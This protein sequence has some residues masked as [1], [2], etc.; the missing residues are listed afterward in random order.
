MRID[1]TKQLS[2]HELRSSV[3]KFVTPLE[4]FFIID[5]TVAEVLHTL[6]A[7][8]NVSKSNYF[9]IIHDDRSLA[10]II[11]AP[12]L[13]YAH[14]QTRISEILEQEI[15]KIHEEEPLEK[16][17]QIL[18]D[19]QILI[20][21]VVDGENKLLGVLE[22]LPHSD[23]VIY[24]PK[25]FGYKEMKSDIFQFI[26]FSLEQKKLQ[27][28]WMG[29]RY[30]MPWLLCNLVGGLI[31][32]LIGEFFQ[33]TLKE[34]VV[35]ALFIPLVLTLSESISIQSMTLSLRFLHIRK[36]QWRQVAKRI[37]IE[38]K[39]S[40]LIAL[41]CSFFIALFY[42]LW[43]KNVMP[44]IAITSSL[45]MAMVVAATFGALFPIFLHQFKLDPKVAAGPVIL[46]LTDIVTV[47]IYLGLST[48]LLIN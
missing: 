33:I 11:T 47:A 24:S 13:L 10:G 9:Y 19:H 6:Q 22:V 42:F 14:P 2:H 34:F 35:L 41:T 4:D 26:G 15:V 37:I 17:L 12:D 30:R 38:W 28:A 36:I 39:I 18:S 43:S 16:A 25:Q 40:F 46:M 1:L 5:H 3:K 45:L 44:I 8:E 29:F 48:L 21:P 20:L 7:K 23:D 31:C 32:A 27:S